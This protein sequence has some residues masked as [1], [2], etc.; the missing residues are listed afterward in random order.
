MRVV[1]MIPS[2]GPASFGG[3]VV[4]L[5]LVREQCRLGVGAEIWSLDTAADREWASRSYGV[6]TEAIKCF[7]PS[8]PARAL[9]S[10][11]MEQAARREGAGIA[12]VHQHAI[13]AG[14]SRISLA[15]RMKHGIPTV[16]TPHGSL[17]KWALGKSGFKKKIALA[18]YEHENLKQASCLYACSEPEVASFRDFGLKNPVAVIPNGVTSDWLSCQGNAGDFRSQHKIPD[19]KKIILFLSRISP[20]KGLP[21]LI[22]ALAMNRDRLREWH[23]VI[24]GAD[25]FNHKIDV[26]NLIQTKNLAENVTFSGQ[27]FDQA[28]VDAFAAADLFVLPT[29]SENFGIVVI[30]ALGTGTPVITTKGAPW[31][32]LLSSGCGWWADVTQGAITEAL[33]DAF[34]RTP[35]QLREMGQRGKELVVSSFTWQQAAQKT[36]RLYDWLLG[37]GEQPDFVITD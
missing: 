21:M 19:G 14:L 8:L 34:S 33:R 6:D 11:K 18:L 36:V 16:V 5:N 28:K 32:L 23:L 20:K 37:R 17:E 26:E 4:A 12:L 15:A 2:A 27:L 13:W 29:L 22:E 3:G 31:G 10:R 9:W 1:H 30:E 35:E 24:A 7:T 25:E